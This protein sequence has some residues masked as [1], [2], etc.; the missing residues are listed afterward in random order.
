MVKLGT[1]S[2]DCVVEAFPE[3]EQEEK[4]TGPVAPA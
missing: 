3:T 2:R 1:P 4:L